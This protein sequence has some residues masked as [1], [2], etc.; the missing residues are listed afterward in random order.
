[1]SSASRRTSTSSS[2]T[3]SSVASSSSSSSAN[4]RRETRPRLSSTAIAR[5]TA[6]PKSVTARAYGPLGGRTTCQVVRRFPA[7]DRQAARGVGAAFEA[8]DALALDRLGRV[9]ETVLDC[10]LFQPSTTPSGGAYVA[11]LAYVT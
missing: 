10:G 3:T 5:S 4:A 1:M 8:A 2:H 9:F 6:V 11:R 7:R